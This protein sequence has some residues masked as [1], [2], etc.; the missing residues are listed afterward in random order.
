MNLTQGKPQTPKLTVVGNTTITLS[1]PIQ[2]H[3]GPI[4]ELTLREPT[5]GDWI[6]CGELQKTSMHIDEQGTRT[7]T[8][9]PDPKA[10]GNWLQRLSGVPLAVF[11]HMEYRDFQKV[12]R[13]LQ[14]ITSDEV[15][16]AGNS[17]TPSPISG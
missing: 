1:K 5:M 9:Q 10:V 17:P 13:E 16:D 3:H 2:G 8:V 4:S 7:M 12:Y 11:G 6:E 14:R 15:G